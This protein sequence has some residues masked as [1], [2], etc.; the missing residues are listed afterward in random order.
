MPQISLH[1]PGNGK[2]KTPVPLNAKTKGDEATETATEGDDGE[3]PDDYYDR[4]GN[5]TQSFTR[6]LIINIKHINLQE[7]LLK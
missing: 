4:C 1:D 7:F 3:I 5:N 6:Y 2:Q